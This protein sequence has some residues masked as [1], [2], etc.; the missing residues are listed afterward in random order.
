MLRTFTVGFRNFIRVVFY[1]SWL[2]PVQLTLFCTVASLKVPAMNVY[3]VAT[4]VLDIEIF[5]Q[6]TIANLNLW[7]YIYCFVQSG[8]VSTVK[9]N[10]HTH[11]RNY[12]T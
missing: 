1:F 6:H 12:E 11:T 9:R 3:D 4:K 8:E 5:S 2:F 10:K 7:H